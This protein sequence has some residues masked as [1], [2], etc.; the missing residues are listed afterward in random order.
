MTKPA[1][2]SLLVLVLLSLLAGCASPGL[3]GA[4]FSVLAQAEPT[5]A[6]YQPPADA[7]PT[8]TPFRPIPP[9]PALHT[10]PNPHPPPTPTEV[11]V[12]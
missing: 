5:Q 12:C 8:P 4:Q 10:P 7:T 9:T 1:S 11:G 6:I 3:V 2:R